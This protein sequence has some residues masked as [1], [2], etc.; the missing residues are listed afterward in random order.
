MPGAALISFAI[1]ARRRGVTTYMKSWQDFDYV[2]LVAVPMFL[3][4]GDVL[5]AERLPARRSP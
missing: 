2:L 1:A 3:F 5:P 4:S